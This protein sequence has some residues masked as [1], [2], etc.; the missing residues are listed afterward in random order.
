MKN[1]ECRMKNKAIRMVVKYILHSSFFTPSPSGELEGGFLLLLHNHLLAIH[2][3]DASLERAMTA[4][5]Q[6]VDDIQIRMVV[7]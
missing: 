6:V 1:E 4:S 2:D 3:I 7:C 5:L